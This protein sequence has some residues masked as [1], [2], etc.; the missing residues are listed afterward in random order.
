MVSKYGENDLLKEEVS[1]KLCVQDRSSWNEFTDCTM[2]R[3]WMINQI[4]IPV[5]WIF[6]LHCTAGEF[7]RQLQ[8]LNIRR[9]FQK[10]ILANQ[11][12]NAMCGETDCFFG[13]DCTLVLLFV[14]GI[15]YF[16]TERYRLKLT[17]QKKVN[18]S[19]R[20][21]AVVPEPKKSTFCGTWLGHPQ[22]ILWNRFLQ[23][24]TS[25]FRG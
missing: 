24:N 7:C 20:C 3:Q 2:K 25:S 17:Q 15:G 16:G 9:I 23:C 22:H 21:P 18:Y 13:P 12:S 10:H 14:E 8:N 5:P 4:P 11:T 6:Q 19:K 1:L